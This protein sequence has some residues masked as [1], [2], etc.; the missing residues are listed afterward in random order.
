MTVRT[1]FAPSPTGFLHIGGVRT[2]LFNWLFAKQ[3]GGQFLLRIDDTDQSRNLDEALAPILDGFRWLGLDWDEG[4]E[5]DGPYAPY[6]QSQRSGR[7][8]AAVDFLLKSGA[9]YRDYSTAEEYG[10]EK[11]AAR[12]EKRD[13]LYSRTWMADTPEKEKQFQQEGRSSVVRL[14]MPRDGRCDFT[15]LI[16]DEQSYLWSKEADHVIQRADGSFIYHLAS[17][18]DDLDFRITH[19]I[20]AIEHLPN[21]PRQ[22]F[23]AKA[24]LEGDLFPSEVSVPEFA[25]IPYVAEP[26]GKSK[27]S[28]RKIANYMKRQEFKK[29]V[30]HGNSIADQIG[31][32]CDLEAFNPVLVDF[33]K[34]VG[35]LP[36]SVLNYLL[37]LGWSLDDKTEDFDIQQMLKHFGLDRVIKAPA[38]FD[39][40]KLMAF[41]ARHMQDVSAD[42]KVPMVL[43]FMAKAGMIPTDQWDQLPEDLQRKV[44]L[45]VLHAEDRLKVAGDILQFGDFFCNDGDLVFEEKPFQKRMVKPAEAE[46]RLREYLKVLSSFDDFETASLKQMTVDFCESMG[47][48]LK[49]IV[50]AIR[51]S[52][53]GKAAGFGLFES[54]EVLGKES[55]LRRCEMALDHLQSIRSQTVS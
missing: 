11:N 10:A 52:A 37:L 55:T 50:H 14:K 47:I 41:Q 38:A 51:V 15:D 36:A 27:L 5:V 35:Y 4:P 17:V 45:V 6:F 39:P 46:H 13:F 23:I 24:L 30:D 42:E 31:L 12:E 28:K 54:M 49:D 48:G 26:G 22:I 18:V 25:H 43:P 40:E 44:R 32:E 8:Q 2:A 53:T 16:R 33:Y 7:Y 20:R 1:R 21:T 9:A 19:V 3:N 34:Q 29:I